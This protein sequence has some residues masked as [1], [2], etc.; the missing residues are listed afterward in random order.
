MEDSF[1]IQGRGLIVVPGPLKSEYVGSRQ[2]DVSLEQPNGT[3][4]SAHLTMQQVRW[5]CILRGVS[6]ADVPPGTKVWK[7]CDQAI[8]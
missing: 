7:L 8:R 3:L 6:K 4:R 1:D 5:T 2:I